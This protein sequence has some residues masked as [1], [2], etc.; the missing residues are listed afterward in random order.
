MVARFT[1]WL[2][3]PTLA[4]L[5]F[6]LSARSALWS[7]FVTTEMDELAGWFSRIV[8]LEDEDLSLLGRLLGERREHLSLAVRC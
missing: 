3:T 6:G 8:Q 4:I 5:V 2:K 1:P 7:N